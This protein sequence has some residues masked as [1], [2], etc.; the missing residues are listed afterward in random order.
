VELTFVGGVDRADAGLVSERLGA[1]PDFE[2]LP[3]EL[4]FHCEPRGI[5]DLLEGRT[6]LAGFRDAIG[7]RWW[8]GRLERIVSAQQLEAALERLAAGYRDD[9]V[10]SCRRLF[11]DL[12]VPLA[13]R[14]GKPGLV[15][16]SSGTL[17]HAPTLD[18]LFGEARFVHVVRDGREVA[19]RQGATRT[20]GQLLAGVERWAAGL[21][22]IDSGVRVREEG[23]A[24]GVW[25]ERLFVVVLGAD[26]GSLE[27]LS[28]FLGLGEPLA[29]GLLDPEPAGQPGAGWQA[30][31]SRR[32]RR[33]VAR[34]YERT[35]RELAAEGVHCAPALLQARE[36]AGP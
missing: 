23:A 12:A 19:A 32:E 14:A 2:A 10:G 34:R 8:T 30:G 3:V 15:E 21:R 25:P 4:G 17:V 6:S 31:L 5:P 36:A 18:R 13:E 33:R 20:P 26:G 9:P 35:L 27:G 22:A 28:D 16:R 11:L 1:T 7:E 29:S 24:Y